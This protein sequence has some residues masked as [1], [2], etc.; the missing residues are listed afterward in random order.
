MNFGSVGKSRMTGKLY[1]RRYSPTRNK[2]KQISHPKDKVTTFGWSIMCY[3][4]FLDTGSWRHLKRFR[5]SETPL[6]WSETVSRG[7]IKGNASE[8]CFISD[9]TRPTFVS[10]Y[11]T[12]VSFCPRWTLLFLL[13]RDGPYCFFWSEMGGIYFRKSRKCRMPTSDVRDIFRMYL[14]HIISDAPYFDE[15]STVCM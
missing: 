8:T 15:R 6:G 9:L 13:V 14:G 11:P 10:F 7:Y 4:I 3:N 5:W 2:Q 12:F 1:I